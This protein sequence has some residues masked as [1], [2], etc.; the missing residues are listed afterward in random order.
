MAAVIKVGQ[1][2]RR[3]CI[4]AENDGWNKLEIVGK[5][6]ITADEFEWSVRPVNG[7]SVISATAASIENAFE[8][9]SEPPAKAIN[10]T[11]R[12]PENE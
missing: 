8:L 9:V 11:E 2:W 10:P 1:I 5:Q 3:R 4:P 12:W 7:L 6:E